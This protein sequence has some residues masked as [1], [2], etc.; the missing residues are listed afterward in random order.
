MTF[1]V[2]GLFAA[3]LAGFLVA[4]AFW[5]LSS[6][7]YASTLV[8]CAQGGTAEKLNDGKFYYFVHEAEYVK[9]LLARA[10]LVQREKANSEGYPASWARV[11]LM[12]SEDGEPHVIGGDRVEGAGDQPYVGWERLQQYFLM[13]GEIPAAEAWP[14]EAD[15]CPTDKA[16]LQQYWREQA[17]SQGGL[18]ELLLLCSDSLSHW[19]NFALERNLRSEPDIQGTL[20]LTQAAVTKLESQLAPHRE[21]LLAAGALAV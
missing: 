11:D 16:A 21:Q 3:A 2:N 13:H 14:H 12:V 7:A 19:L 18:T 4:C 17:Q 15:G 5:F 8:Y 9:L 20:V 1:T 6:R 10:N